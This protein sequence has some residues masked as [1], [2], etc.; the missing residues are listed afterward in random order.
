VS[1]PPRHP[2][3][4][5]L[6]GR[7]AIVFGGLMHLMVGAFVLASVG[8]LPAPRVAAVAGV[9]VVLAVLGWRWRHSRPPVVVLLPFA[10]ALVVWL[11]ARGVS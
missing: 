10:A 9:W 5:R 4:T 11:A 8:V 3:A 6:A 2:A 7:V 1:S